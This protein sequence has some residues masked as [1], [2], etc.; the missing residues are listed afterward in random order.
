[1]CIPVSNSLFYW[2][3]LGAEC[4]W[5]ECRHQVQLLFTTAQSLDGLSCFPQSCGR[6]MKHFFSFM[7]RHS[8]MQGR[9]FKQHSRGRL[10]V[11]ERRFQGLGSFLLHARSFLCSSANAAR[12]L[13]GRCS[14]SCNTRVP[15]GFCSIQRPDGSE[16]EEE[17]K[18]QRKTLRQADKV[19]ACES[20]VV[21]WPG[22]RNVEAFPARCT[23]EEIASDS[24]CR[25]RSVFIDGLQ[26]LG[27]LPVFNLFTY[28]QTVQV[29]PLRLQPLSGNLSCFTRFFLKGIFLEEEHCFCEQQ[30][31]CPKGWQTGGHW[32]ASPAGFEQNGQKKNKPQIQLRALRNNCWVYISGVRSHEVVLP[33]CSECFQQ[34]ILREV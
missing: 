17:W 23:N 28:F 30:N 15:T 34:S 8:E 5:H 19:H 31:I 6:Y 1:M 2:M 21:L 4:Q 29:P 26:N 11:N 13:N 24:W 12:C 16:R 20:P 25:C 10:C 22:C 33:A 9:P 3:Y 14:P 7:L 18:W 32:A 27:N